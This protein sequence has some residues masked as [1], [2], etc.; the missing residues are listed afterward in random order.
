MFYEEAT[1]LCVLLFNHTIFV[2][3]K[4]SFIETFSR[5]FLFCQECFGMK[6][7]NVLNSSISVA[8]LL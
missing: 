7:N 2:T 8:Q 6:K 1:L 5:V 4:I 3:E